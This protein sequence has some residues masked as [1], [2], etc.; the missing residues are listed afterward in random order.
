LAKFLQDLPGCTSARVVEALDSKTLERTP[1]F[2]DL[3]KLQGRGKFS[4]EGDRLGLLS[5]YLKQATTAKQSSKR[6]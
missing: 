5:K 1:E 3:L 6:A 4:S 2:F